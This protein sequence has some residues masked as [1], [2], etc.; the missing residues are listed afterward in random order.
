MIAK[1]ICH[2]VGPDVKIG[3]ELDLHCDLTDQM[4]EQADAIVIYKEYPHTDIADRAVDLF[5][6]MAEATIGRI[7]PVMAM[8]DCRILGLYLTPYVFFVLDWGS[9]VSASVTRL[10]DDS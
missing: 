3:V 6:L 8:F 5:E 9:F 1:Q 10:V 2:I 4:I 7:K